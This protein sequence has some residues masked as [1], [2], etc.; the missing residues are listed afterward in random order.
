MT[1]NRFNLVQGKSGL[2]WTLWGE[3]LWQEEEKARPNEN[4]RKIYQKERWGWGWWRVQGKNCVEEN[5]KFTQEEGADS[6]T[7]PSMPS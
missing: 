4:I 7:K 1:P 5:R 6:V 3:A 2:Q